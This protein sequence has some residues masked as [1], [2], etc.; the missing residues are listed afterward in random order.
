MTRF[1]VA[2]AL[3]FAGLMPGIVGHALAADLPEP[4]APPPRAPATY[5][6]TVAPVYN[7]GGIYFGVNGGYGFGKSEWTQA[8]ASTGTFNTSGYAFGGGAGANFQSDAFVFGVE[9]DFDAM[10]LDGTATCLPT[11]CE[12][13]DTWLATARARAGYAVDRVLFYGTAGGAF[14]NIQANTANLTTFQSTTKAGWTAGGGVEAALADNW[15]ARIEYLFVDLQNGSF[16]SPA[17]GP[18]TVKFD[19]SVIR[20]GVDYKFR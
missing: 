17:N 7:W 10:G 1:V 8:A 15:T 2:V 13:R 4:A 11:N 5:I 12:T 20:L 19:A 6:P 9:A 18:I 14:G 16:S 3:G